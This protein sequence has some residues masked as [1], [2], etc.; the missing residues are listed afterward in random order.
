MDEK[1]IILQVKP[2]SST[3][4]LQPLIKNICEITLNCVLNFN[5]NILY[6]TLLYQIFK[7][8]VWTLETVYIFIYKIIDMCKYAYF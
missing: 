7:F 3:F 2:I 8:L 1:I 4:K 5:N 6:E